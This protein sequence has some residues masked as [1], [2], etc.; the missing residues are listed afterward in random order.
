MDVRVLQASGNVPPRLLRDRSR[1]L[2]D[3]NIDHSGGRDTL[4]ALPLRE[5]LTREETKDQAAG[6]EPTRP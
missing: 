4:N 3:V 2:R 5:M 1:E 6:R